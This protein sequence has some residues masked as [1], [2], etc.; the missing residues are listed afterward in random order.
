M[1]RRPA[2]T[3]PADPCRGNVVAV[4][5]DKDKVGDDMGD[6]VQLGTAGV[7]ERLGISAASVR[8]YTVS[9]RGQY[10]FPPADGYLDRK[11]WWWSDTIDEWAANRPGRG[12]GGGR[13]RKPEPVREVSSTARGGLAFVHDGCSK[14]HKTKAAAEACHEKTG[15]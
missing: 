6:R 12:V 11:P 3:C 7:G 13:P 8:R 10:A 5:A 1:I 9:D 14:R 15:A 4:N 2:T